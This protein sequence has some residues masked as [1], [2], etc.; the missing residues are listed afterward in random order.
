MPW[1]RSG[2]SGFLD[3]GHAV[4][5]VTFQAH[6]AAL[7]VGVRR[8]E[9]DVVVRLI[10]LRLQRRTKRRAG[11]RARVGGAANDASHSMPRAC[12]GTEPDARSPELRNYRWI[13]I[14]C[15]NGR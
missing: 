5:I 6:E 8:S 13:E 4:R 14:R 7:L 12:S 11:G 3:Q 10:K 1:R 15:A 2:R 9:L